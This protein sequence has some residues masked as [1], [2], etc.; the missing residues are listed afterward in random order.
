LLEQ[1]RIAERLRGQMAA[2]A[3]ARAAAEEELRTISALP[4]A[5]LRRAFNGEI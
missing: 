5:V 2:V 3:K 4:A 1:Q